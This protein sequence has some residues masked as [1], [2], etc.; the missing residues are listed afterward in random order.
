LKPIQ[1][2][3]RAPVAQEVIV[4]QCPQ[5]RSRVGRPRVGQ[6]VVACLAAVAALALTACSSGTSHSSAPAAANTSAAVAPSTS[7]GAAPTS[8]AA[9]SQP[10]CPPTAGEGVT[11]SQI[12][13]AVTVIA[14]SSGSLTN[15]SVGVPSIQEQEADWN[16]VASNINNSGGAAC[17]K[18]ALKFYNVNPVDAAAA[19]QS[20]LTIAASHPFMVL[21]SGSLTNVGAS[22]C[23]P[24]Q[25]VPLMS[26]YLTQDKL[27]KYYPY[28][29]QVGDIPDDALHNGILGLNQLGYFSAAKGFHKLGNLYH[30]C[31]PSLETA[32]LAALKEA[33]IP[34][35]QIVSFNLGCQGGQPDTP[36]ALEQAVLQFKNA[37]VT[38]VTEAG[39]GD[40]G[41]FTQVAQQQNFKPQY[42]FDDGAL[43]A[44]G[45][46]PGPNLLNTA[47]VTGAVDI[48]N[49][50]Y[51]E[52]TT[53]GYQPSG[54][55]AKCNAI[56]AAA[57]Q[58][59]V[60]QQ[61]DG[62]G[63]VVCS[64]L[65]FVAALAN[66]ATSLQASALATAMHSIGR[67]DF[68]YPAAPIDFS[69]APAGAVYGVSY[70]RA[71]QYVTSCK[72]WQVP[73]PTFHP[74]FK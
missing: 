39:V 67:L 35:N 8:S 19:Q 32:Q 15:A 17:R 18:L 69:A 25:K 31:T 24:T 7:A 63:G 45:N 43:P 71:L 3:Q 73:D 62:Y 6:R 50:G 21:D 51:G 58:P 28:Y 46:N 55:T 61:K 53:P 70:W 4:K 5:V 54:G 48:V 64:Y 66:H 22:D 34:D 11:A 74:P 10:V 56:F 40:V 1:R 47:N 42:L 20:C 30:T 68:S 72:C 27:T 29:L 2:P 14:I 59:T 41:S 12:T 33:G 60:Y 52:Q 65:T 26:A 37:G 38:A 36:A 9:T 23:I 13:L 44:V 57:G 16:L 49:T